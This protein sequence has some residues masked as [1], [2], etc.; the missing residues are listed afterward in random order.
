MQAT[1]ELSDDL[2]Q[3]PYLSLL[4][5]SVAVGVV[6]LLYLF[7]LAPT[8][9]GVVPR[10]QLIFLSGQLSVTLFGAYLVVVFV[11]RSATAAPDTGQSTARSDTSGGAVRHAAD[12]QQHSDGD[13]DADNTD[14]D[15][16]ATDIGDDG[17]SG[18]NSDDENSTHETAMTQFTQALDEHLGML[19][20]WYVAAHPDSIG[21]P[22]ASYD[23]LFDGDFAETV[24]RLDFAAPHEG[25]PH[26]GTWIAWSA[27][28]L[29]EFR[30]ET[31]AIIDVHSDSIDPTV[32]AS[33]HNLANSRLTKRVITADEAA[34]PDHLPADTALVLFT[35][36]DSDDPLHAHLE[37]LREMLATH[38]THS[39]MAVTPPAERDCWSGDNPEAGV[40]R[41][42]AAGDAEQ[43]YK[44]F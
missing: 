32:G 17:G 24:R 43:Y 12:A 19:C 29:T 2:L 25:E 37:L 1:P 35:E 33:L 26:D 22:P 14:R 9:I 42:N 6:Y 15:G 13:S 5:S 8:L 31:M 4:V 16:E 36:A 34:L 41:A 23:A 3:W 40:A 11:D 38:E 7:E 28:R 21:E 27:V 44:L 18:D 30:R 10:S 20:A 39:A